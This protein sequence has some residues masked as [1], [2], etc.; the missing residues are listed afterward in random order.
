MLGTP[1]TEHGSNKEVLKRMG[2]KKEINTLNQ[3]EKVEIPKTHNE[4][5]GLGELGIHTRYL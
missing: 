4:E 1:W 5:K 3:K 2:N